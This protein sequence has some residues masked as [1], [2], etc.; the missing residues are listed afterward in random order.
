MTERIPLLLQADGGLQRR[1]DEISALHGQ[2]SGGTHGWAAGRQ[3]VASRQFVEIRVF[4]DRCRPK[5]TDRVG[6]DRCQWPNQADCGHCNRP[7]KSAAA[8][9][10]S[11]GGI[12]GSQSP[13]SYPS[14]FRASSVAPSTFGAQR[15]PFGCVFGLIFVRPQSSSFPN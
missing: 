13:Q 5:I 15:S 14:P 10:S 2:T 11:N 7:K 8:A 9:T 4:K 6:L 3:D 1:S 12:E